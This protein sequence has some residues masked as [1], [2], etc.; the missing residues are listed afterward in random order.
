MLYDF[1]LASV[2][3][4]SAVQLY[5]SAEILSHFDYYITGRLNTRMPK[6]DSVD[7]KCCWHFWKTCDWHSSSLGL[8]TPADWKFV[9]FILVVKLE[10][11]SRARLDF[12]CAAVFLHIHMNTSAVFP[13]IHAAVQQLNYWK[14]KGDLEVN[15]TQSCD[16]K[17]YKLH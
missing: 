2:A 13:T 8:T 16:Y 10:G 4:Y 3:L 5:S 6:V 15:A 11:L 7:I 9:V 17:Q 12:M 1:V 14:L